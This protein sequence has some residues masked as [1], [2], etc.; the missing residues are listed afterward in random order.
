MNSKLRDNTA[1]VF[2]LI[3]ALKHYPKGASVMIGGDRLLYVKI[4]EKLVPVEGPP[5]MPGVSNSGGPVDN[6]G[7]GVMG[8]MAAVRGQA[9]SRHAAQQQQQQQPSQKPA[10]TTTPGEWSVQA[11][12]CADL[13]E[14]IDDIPD[15]G[16]SF[17]ESVREKVT[18]MR[19][20]I[21]NHEDVTDKMVAALDN[22]ADAVDRWID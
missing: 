1:T 4:G 21:E 9:K 10:T 13:L 18:D 8:A 7:V 15:R 3:S 12:R 14:R 5:E 22:I 16:E 2:D 6:G 11:D 19:T 20:W 17:R